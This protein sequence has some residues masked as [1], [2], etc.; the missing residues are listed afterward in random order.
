MN[1]YPEKIWLHRCNSIEKLY[2]QGDEYSNVEVDV[3]FRKNRKFDVTHDADTSFNL[4]LDPYF[5]YMNETDGKIW[6][7]I[8]NLKAGNKTEIFNQILPSVSFI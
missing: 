3:V 4:V 6:L 5:S 8:K 7:D 1:D 2:E